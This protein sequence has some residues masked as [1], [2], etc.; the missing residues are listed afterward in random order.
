[1][2]ESAIDIVVDYAP[3][4]ALPYWQQMAKVGV[5]PHVTLLYPWR[6]APIDGDSLATLRAVAAQFTPFE[7]SMERVETFPKGVVYVTLEPDSALRSM[8]R[9]LAD[10]FPDTPPFG[11]EF[12]PRGPT[13]HCTLAKADGD[14]DGLERL[15]AELAERLDPVL[16]AT[17]TVDSICVEEEADSG[18]WSIT[19]TIPL[20]SSSAAP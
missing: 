16:P 10:V 17:I 11:G 5:P 1:M 13:P 9:A 7:M 3:I 2:L 12:A 6:A 4:T 20:G 14:V 18:M 8:I 15:R 19:T